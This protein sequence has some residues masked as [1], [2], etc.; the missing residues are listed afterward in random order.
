[1][2]ARQLCSGVLIH[3]ENLKSLNNLRSNLKVTS[4]KTAVHEENMI[5]ILNYR[6]K[7]N[8]ESVSSLITVWSDTLQLITDFE[9]DY[10]TYTGIIITQTEGSIS[11]PYFQEN[12]LI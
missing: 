9:N 10:L 8:S 6:D 11:T 4:I 5:I 1:M 2:S 3:L 7:Q 12:L